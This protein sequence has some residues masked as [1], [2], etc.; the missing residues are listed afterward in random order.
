M[1]LLRPAWKDVGAHHERDVRVK[2][3]KRKIAAMPRTEERA[4]LASASH[5]G[6]VAASN[7]KEE[8]SVVAIVSAPTEV[9]HIHSLNEHI[10][11][12]MAQQS[13]LPNK[14][15]CLARGGCFRIMK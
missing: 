15:T 9:R 5:V 6:A 10:G 12:I 13:Y 1:P 11:P 8:A 2:A 4:S 14:Q 7:L 3:M